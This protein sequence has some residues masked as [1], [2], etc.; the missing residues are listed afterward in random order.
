LILIK[1][2]QASFILRHVN[3]NA[4][5]IMSKL[6]VSV[7][8]TVIVIAL[9]G[10]VSMAGACYGGCGDLALSCNGG[11]VVATWSGGPGIDQSLVK[12]TG[13]GGSKVFVISGYSGSV[14]T[15]WQNGTFTIDFRYAKF[16]LD[17]ETITC[18]GA[19]AETT[20]SDG[21]LNNRHGDQIAIFPADDANG[22][23]VQV[24]MLD[25]L[26]IPTFSMEISAEEL[27]ALPDAD[28]LTEAYLISESDDGLV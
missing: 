6:K 4:G 3:G 12:T 21:R 11:S 17:S 19:P 22:R 8:L 10:S 25:G 2:A 15:D 14:T 7:I 5:I 20:F 16:V 1:G 28:T 18:I 23:G 27:A 13:T 24:W 26:T 9:F